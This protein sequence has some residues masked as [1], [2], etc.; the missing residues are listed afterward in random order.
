MNI[1]SPAVAG[2]FYPSSAADLS[3]TISHLFSYWGLDLSKRSKKPS[4]D[5]YGMVL[6]HA[7]YSYSGYVCARTLWELPDVKNIILIGPNH[8]GAGPDISI[9]SADA[10]ETPLGDVLIN[11]DLC[12][13]I[14]DYSRAEFDDSAHANEHSI[15]V[16]L[17]LLQTVLDEF[18][19]VPIALKNYRPDNNF[20]ALC[21][22]LADGIANAI[23][24]CDLS[25][26]TY[27][28][29]STDFSHYVTDQQAR[30]NDSYAIEAI[31]RLDA[32]G[33]FDSVLR[34][35]ISMCGYG[36]VA[37]VLRSTGSLGASFAEKI[38]Y[39]TSAETGT[40]ESAVVGYGGMR[41]L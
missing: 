36:G 10:W 1:R 41:I 15:E 33:L 23:G 24:D 37:A 32:E 18:S 38:A 5:S 29:A 28:I 25:G 19:I 9:S 3:A 39:M 17:P 27:L 16:Q 11:E 31:V 8:T 22:D 34:H 21:M 12:R 40:A 7:G 4:K 30:T 26:D 6:P 20:L 14:S 13:S 2:A 35:D